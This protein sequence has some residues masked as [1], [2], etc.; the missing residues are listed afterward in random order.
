MNLC[1]IVCNL[2][3]CVCIRVRMES[4]NK[5]EMKNRR[6]LYKLSLTITHPFTKAPRR[7]EGEGEVSAARAPSLSPLV[8]H[9]ESEPIAE[10]SEGVAGSKEGGKGC[11]VEGFRKVD[12]F[13]FE[14]FLCFIWFCS[15]LILVLTLGCFSLSSLITSPLSPSLCLPSRT[16]PSGSPLWMNSWIQWISNKKKFA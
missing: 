16:S 12:I 4:I 14:Y 13:F 10:H 6:V 8:W 9:C 15:K 5:W 7:G 11:A 2:D 3:V 1:L